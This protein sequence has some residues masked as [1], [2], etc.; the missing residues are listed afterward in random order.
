M[1][2]N[3][4]IKGLIKPIILKLLA[5]NGKMYGYEITRKVEDLTEGKIKLTFGALYPILHKLEAD[6]IVGTE[7]EMVSNRA[8]VY[9]LLTEQGKFSAREKIAELED[10][11]STLS[12]L[13]NPEPGLLPC[14][15]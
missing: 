1:I 2:S 3:N 5:E 8:R 14:T 9:Y 15:S 4:F 13:I 11:V 7:T 10:F 6:G 12:K